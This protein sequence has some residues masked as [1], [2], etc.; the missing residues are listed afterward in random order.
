MVLLFYYYYRLSLQYNGSME[1]LAQ[2]GL[3]HV[4]VQ[5]D[6]EQVDSGQYIYMKKE[7]LICPF[8]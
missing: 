4:L 8:S 1:G 5:W 6:P 7:S 2:Q 3:W